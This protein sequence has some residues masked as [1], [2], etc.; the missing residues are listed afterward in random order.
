MRLVAPSRPRAAWFRLRALAVALP[1]VLAASLAFAVP[2][3][4]ATTCLGKTVTKLGTAS[5]N[6]IQG[7]AG[8]DVIYGGGGNDTIYGLVATTSSA[9]APG[10]TAST[11]ATATI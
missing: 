9:A 1:M 10:T 7:T 6:V 11:A 3:S 2:A 8:T 5:A 4:A